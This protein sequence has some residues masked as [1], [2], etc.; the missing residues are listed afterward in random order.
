[1]V[2]HLLFCICLH[3]VRVRP[4]GASVFGDAVSVWR[5]STV[6]GDAQQCLAT[7]N[8]VWW[9]LFAHSCPPSWDTLLTQVLVLCPGDIL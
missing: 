1:M 9:H 6:F 7:L 3:V 5:H 4:S 2:L 8:S